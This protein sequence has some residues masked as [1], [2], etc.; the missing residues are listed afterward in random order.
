MSERKYVF[1]LRMLTSLLSCLCV[2]GN[3][4]IAKDE[5]DSSVWLVLVAHNGLASEQPW[6]PVYIYNQKKFEKIKRF[7]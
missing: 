4:R 3:A 6:N 5:I 7:N 2:K 1:E